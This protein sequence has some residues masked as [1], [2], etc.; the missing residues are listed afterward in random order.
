MKRGLFFAIGGIVL[1]VSIFLISYYSFLFFNSRKPKININTLEISFDDFG[2]VK[3]NDQEPINDNQ[4]DQI[5]PY[6][7]TIKNK[8]QNSVKYQLLIEDFVTDKNTKL[9]SRKY[10]NY[11][12][13]LNDIVL[14]SENLSNVKNNIIDSGIIKANQKKTYELR[15]WVAENTNSTEWMGKSYNY[16]IS[17]NPIID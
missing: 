11:K 14:K 4:V 3:L 16:N 12:L 17:V 15:I 5:T 13:T 10:L 7:F 6:K 9:L 1:L 2:K 8:N